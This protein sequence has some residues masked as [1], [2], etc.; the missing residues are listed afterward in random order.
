[1]G[2]Q[3]PENNS[4][5]KTV[6]TPIA[7]LCQVPSTGLQLSHLRNQDLTFIEHPLVSGR[8]LG[9]MYVISWI[10]HYPTA[11]PANREKWGAGK[12]SNLLQAES[13]A[14]ATF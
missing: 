13:V 8:V 12:E 1:M 2:T 4:L 10:S 9:A 5:M 6:A 3:C 7:A 11:L 14:S